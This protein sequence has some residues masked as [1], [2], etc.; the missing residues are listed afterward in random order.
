MQLDLSQF[1]TAL[2]IFFVLVN[3]VAF[4]LVRDGSRRLFR[5]GDGASPI[6][7]TG[8]SLLSG[9]FGVKLGESIFGD[10]HESAL[11]SRLIN[12]IF[13]GYIGIFGY[14][15]VMSAPENFNLN[16][17]FYEILTGK[18]KVDEPD[19]PDRFGPVATEEVSKS[20][21]VETDE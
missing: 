21:K 4:A 3:L 8:L 16:H 10:V 13:V 19:L 15:A 11:F 18:Q 6:A 9:V 12:L 7:L 1:T 17:I 14:V 20:I 5:D 2:V